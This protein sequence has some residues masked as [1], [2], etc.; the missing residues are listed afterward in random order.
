MNVQH[1]ASPAR[2]MVW[3]ATSIIGVESIAIHLRRTGL[4]AEQPEDP[5]AAAEIGDAIA[6]TQ[7]PGDC[8]P[9]GVES[10]AIGDIAQ[11][12]FKHGTRV[13]SGASVSGNRR[14]GGAK[15]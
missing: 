13:G 6:G 14:T 3:R 15:A 4:E 5:G 10:Y 2:A 1:S 12:F 7:D 8:R 11:M 9:K